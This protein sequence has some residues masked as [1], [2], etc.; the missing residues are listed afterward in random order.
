MDCNDCE[1]SWAEHV[2][3]TCQVRERI[4]PD[5]CQP[6]EQC[7]CAKDVDML[8]TKMIKICELTGYCVVPWQVDIM[9]RWLLYGE[10]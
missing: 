2:N 1:H 9:R 3:G 5:H 6:A 10:P 7:G 8:V 4:I